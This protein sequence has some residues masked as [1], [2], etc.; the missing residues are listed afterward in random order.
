MLYDIVY[1]R[2]SDSE[3]EE[4]YNNDSEELLKNELGVDSFA[5]EF[6]N[7]VNVNVVGLALFGITYS[8]LLWKFMVNICYACFWGIHYLALYVW[9]S[10]DK[11]QECLQLAVIV[12]SIIAAWGVLKY[13]RDLDERIDN[14]IMK[15]KA[16][17]AE[18]DAIIARLSS[19]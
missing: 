8:Y 15:L 18:K 4:V 7:M 19:K 9:D 12:F 1:G 2:D 14:C 11:G 10:L 3:G 13:A 5:S 16:E 17:L 6:V